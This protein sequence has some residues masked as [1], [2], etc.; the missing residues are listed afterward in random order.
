M[1]SA[2]PL[3][4]IRQRVRVDGPPHKTFALPENLALKIVERPLGELKP[5]ARNARTHS[6]KQ[7]AEIRDSVSRFGFI[8]PILIDG[9]D[10]IVAGHGRYMAA[11]SLAMQ[12][13]P[14]ITIGH[15][16]ADEIRAY[17]LADNRLAE[18]AGW[19]DDLLK[20]ELGHL[21]E[22]DF[23]VDL[24]GFDTPQIDL[25]LDGEPPAKPDP[26]DDVPEI[27]K[28]AVTRL[29]DTWKTGKHLIFC[30]NALDRVSYEALMAGA[31]AQMVFIDVPYNVK[32]DGHVGGKGSAFAAAFDFSRPGKPTDNAFIEAFNG[33]LRAECLNAHWFLTLADAQEKLEA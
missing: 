29:G 7:I 20:L 3:K 10:E 21:V 2:I 33:H 31:P 4:P 30:G 12:T 32:I 14:T 9:N 28:E 17:R 23:D 24:T 11:E 26:A 6:D 25:I 19:D 18:L 8:T 27:V 13:V 15:L 5:S 22:V 16:S 1:S